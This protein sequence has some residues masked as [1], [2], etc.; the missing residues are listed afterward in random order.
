MRVLLQALGVAQVC[1]GAWAQLQPFWLSFGIDSPP[2]NCLSS[3]A[4]MF[5]EETAQSCVELGEPGAAQS[6]LKAGD[7]YASRLGG[8][9][10]WLGSEPVPSDDIICKLC[11]S[12]LYQVAQVVL[13]ACFSMSCRCTL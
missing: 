8:T 7:P 4:A 2:P 11:G 6:V 13:E 10:A 12:P 3:P 9:P 5:A 1:N